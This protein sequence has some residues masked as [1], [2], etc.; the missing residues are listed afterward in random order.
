MRRFMAVVAVFCV[1][2]ASPVFAAGIHGS[3]KDPSGGAVSAAE[4]LVLTPARAVVATVRTDASGR[5]EVKDLTPGSYLL[6][7]RSPSFEE[8]SA[9]VEVTGA[10]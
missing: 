3:V 9:A 8:R 4:V 5:F 7:A 6:L 1:A 2:A 10:P